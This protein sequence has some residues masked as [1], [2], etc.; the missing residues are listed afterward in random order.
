M[1]RRSLMFG[2]G[3]ALLA[4]TAS[5]QE[6]PFLGD[7]LGGGDLFRQN[8]LMGGSFATA[9]SRLALARSR[10]REVRR[11]ATA[12][13]AEQTTVAEALAAVPGSAPVRPDQEALIA[14]L[15]SASPRD[16]DAQYVLGQLVG[17][18]ELLALNTGYEQTGADL[19]D[20]QVAAMS[21]PIIHRH[22]G[23][24]RELHAVVA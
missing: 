13:I 22:L 21:L 9:T 4:G 23:I 24:L 10:R 2:I 7:V 18:H 16:F 3:G 15:E 5:A 11:F 12:E 1:D 17:H 19:R 14:Q 20:R 6:L 8:D